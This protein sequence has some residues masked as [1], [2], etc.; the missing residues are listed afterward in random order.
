VTSGGQKIMTKISMTPPLKSRRRDLSISGDVTINN[1][2]ENINDSLGK[3]RYT[4]TIINVDAL[5]TMAS[6][7]AK[8]LRS[9]YSACNNQQHSL[10]ITV[11]LLATLDGNGGNGR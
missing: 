4:V 7:R 1:F 11:S 9:L 2:D 3:P 6:L 5:F 8:A 10:L